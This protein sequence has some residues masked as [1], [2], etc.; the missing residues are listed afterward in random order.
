MPLEGLRR[1]WSALRSSRRSG[2]VGRS[3]TSEVAAYRGRPGWSIEGI[4]NGTVVARTVAAAQPWLFSERLAQRIHKVLDGLG[5][6][7]WAVQPLR[8]RITLWSVREEDF[9]R[10]V[11]AVRRDLADEGFYVRPLGARRI[12]L[13]EQPL[14]DGI[15]SV[16]GVDIFRYVRDS[17][18]RVTSNYERC[19]LVRWVRSDRD[20]LTTEVREAVVQEIEDQ[21][22]VPVV[23]VRRWDGSTQ[24]RPTVLAVPDVSEI[25]FEIDAV[26]M[27]VSSAD[28]AWQERQRAAFRRLHL[29]DPTVDEAAQSAVRYR[30]R[31]ELRA[32]MRSL[33]MYAP[34]I[35]RI[36]LVTDDQHPEWLD[37]NSDRVTVVDH[38]EI[39]SDPSVLPCFNSRAIGSQLHRI[40]GLA[41]H[42][43]VVN[44]DVMF[45]RAVSPYDFFTPEGFMKIVLSRSRLARLDPEK[46][47]ALERSR[48]NSAGLI[49]AT[50]GATPTRVFAHI[51]LTQSK[52]IAQEISQLYAA[53]VGQT[54]QHQ[55]RSPFDYETNAWLHQYRAMFTHRAIVTQTPYVYTSPTEGKPRELM[56][57]G[58]AFADALFVCVNDNVA[59][60]EKADDEW[61]VSWLSR[62]YPVP[63][64]FEL[65]DGVLG[66]NTPRLGQTD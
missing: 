58:E 55:F 1:S 60:D 23:E 25:D 48:T 10:A 19:L 62:F 50:H 21:S 63:A 32:S 11:E 51:P 39:F 18:G 61:L 5:V 8:S 45:N 35:R 7:S 12:Y 57:T 54:I 59:P 36:F 31:G 4:A 33:E 52:Q 6:E 64:A 34:W 43:L 53:E 14:P 9:V 22:P 20:T 28:P 24:P 26:Y 56:D 42:Y 27:W 65:A 16:R 2:Q 3:A 46:L 29:Q 38:R 66:G 47:T 17:T 30:D 37:L 49:K 13:A 15:D 44:D 41:E 40:P